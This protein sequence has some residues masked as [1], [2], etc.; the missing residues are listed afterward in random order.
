MPFALFANVKAMIALGVVL[1]IIA[2]GMFAKWQYDT[3]NKLRSS[4]AELALANQVQVATIET[5][6]VSM[7]NFNAK[8][9]MLAEANSRISTE[10]A[11]N[12]LVLANHNLALL[13][14][15]KPGLIELR[16]ND[17]SDRVLKRISEI[18]DP[19]WKP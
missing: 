12:K 15:K 14:A 13:A 5:L 19:K 2:L 17:G 16:V 9:D 6:R 7:S 8:A 4:V 18:T 11:S 3:A 10:V 1:V